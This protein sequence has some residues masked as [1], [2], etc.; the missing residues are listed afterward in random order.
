MTRVPYEAHLKVYET[1][2]EYR[3]MVAYEKARLKVV[4]DTY[5]ENPHSENYLALE[6]HMLLYQNIRCNC[7][8]DMRG[9]A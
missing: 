3:G 9:D 6:Q 5:L 8:W 1:E 7:S 2:M 4:M